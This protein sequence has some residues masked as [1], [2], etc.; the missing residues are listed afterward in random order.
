MRTIYTA[1]VLI[2]GLSSTAAQATP[3]PVECSNDK[4]K[5]AWKAKNG[6][7]SVQA[8]LKTKEVDGYTGRQKLNITNGCEIPNAEAGDAILLMFDKSLS[9]K[10]EYASN[11]EFQ[12]VDANKP[13]GQ[14]VG[15]DA[16]PTADDADGTLWS[17]ICSANNLN[18]EEKKVCTKDTS[19]RGRQDHFKAV[20][21]K[22][23]TYGME[24][25]IRDQG[26]QYQV[27]QNVR[28]TV[29]PSGRL[30]CQY[31]SKEDNN[32][33]FHFSFDIPQ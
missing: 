12:C 31:W 25:Y 16:S 29:A 27:P 23:N 26:F 7:F 6:S 3:V 22:N 9:D 15:W 18:A 28:Q 13:T 8:G 20:L 4:P 21:K 19:N 11:Y 17:P 10:L 14:F 32:V 24:V 5:A 30:F 2:A 1:L 33:L